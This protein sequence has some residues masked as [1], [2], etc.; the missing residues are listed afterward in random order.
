MVNAAK[1][2]RPALPARGH[3][4]GDHRNLQIGQAH[5]QLLAFAHQAQPRLR[6]VRRR[7]LGHVHAGAE[8]VAAA[9]ENQHAIATVAVDLAPGLAERVVH[10]AFAGAPQEWPAAGVQGHQQ[11]AVAV[12]FQSDVGPEPGVVLEPAH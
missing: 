6:L 10:A 12:A 1:R 7:H 8:G 11:H 2:R 9:G 4:R 5:Q 3:A